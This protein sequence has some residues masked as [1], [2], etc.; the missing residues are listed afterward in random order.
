MSVT[1]LLTRVRNQPPKKRWYQA[2]NGLIVI[3]AGRTLKI[4]HV[5]EYPKCGGTWVRNMVQTY[6]GGEA[7]LVNRMANSNTV[8]HL[9]RK[10]SRRFSYPIVLFRDPRDVFVSYYFYEKAA[11]QSNQS[12][13]IGKHFSFSRD[14]DAREEFVGYLDAKLRFTTDPY[15]SYKV[16]VDSWLERNNV[17]YVYYENFKRAPEKELQKIVMHL[18][19]PVD[20]QRLKHAVEHNS[21][22]NVTL[23][24]YGV[25]RK[26]GEEDPSKFQR[27]GISGDWVNYF[28]QEA[29]QVLDYHLGDVLLK[30]N[31]ET[32][33]DWVNVS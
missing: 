3:T 12:L 2:I 22:E 29:R 7:Y 28:N 31:Y 13:A 26:P 20:A 14:M 10:Y 21:F 18:G 17:V 4:S 9:H 6:L 24:K 27:K 8:I 32:S 1:N 30:L 25:S 16:F 19:V 11:I 5:L 33:R 15:F 23:R